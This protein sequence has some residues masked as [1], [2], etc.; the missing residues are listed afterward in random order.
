MCIVH[1][2]GRMPVTMLLDV[3]RVPGYFLCMDSSSG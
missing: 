1:D 3:V 2:A